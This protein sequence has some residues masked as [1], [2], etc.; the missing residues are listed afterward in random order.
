[1]TRNESP[2]PLSYPPQSSGQRANIQ[3]QLQYANTAQRDASQR[4]A[5]VTGA[6]P[7]IPNQRN[8]STE[9]TYPVRTNQLAQ[10]GQ[11]SSSS[12]WARPPT[13]FIRTASD[14]TSS[15]SSNGG[16]PRPQTQQTRSEVW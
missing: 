3:T 15:D 12:Q 11:A 10:T 4:Q 16:A 14:Y 1:M 7:S 5:A 13:R 8:L 2:V 9:A 6:G